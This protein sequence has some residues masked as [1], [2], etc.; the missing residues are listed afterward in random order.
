MDRLSRIKESRIWYSQKEAADLIRAEIRGHMRSGEDPDAARILF[1]IGAHG[2]AKT[3]S[4]QQVAAE[5]GLAYASFHAGAVDSQDNTGLQHIVD[6]KTAHNQPAHIPIFSAPKSESGFGVFV[7]EEFG[8][9]D[10]NEFQNQARQLS[11]GR[12]GE[13]VKHPNWI[14]AAT[15]NPDGDDYSTVNKLDEALVSRLVVVPMR[16]TTEEKLTYWR[17]KPEPKMFE[18]LYWFLTINQALVESA[19]ARSWYNLGKTLERLEAAGCSETAAEQAV[20]I[21]VGDAAAA[22]YRLYLVRGNNPDL[23]PIGGEAALAADAK[24]TA[25]YVARIKKWH[26]ADGGD[27]LIQATKYDLVSAIEHQ[28]SGTT[29]HVANVSALLQAI[30]ANK[31]ADMVLDVIHVVRDKN[32]DAAANLTNALSGTAAG[33]RLIE[34]FDKT[35]KGVASVGPKD[36]SSRPTK[37]KRRADAPR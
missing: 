34:V 16:L 37:S 31:Y 26:A 2:E 27:S 21:A 12:L 3:R 13:L 7:F 30:G 25:L 29:L 15:S 18:K 14:L 24:T 1:L 19:D 22:A 10:N 20:R 9:N 28:A 35:R 4:L 11:E 6:N 36:D 33:N 32:A 23:Y 8:T 5:M 17:H